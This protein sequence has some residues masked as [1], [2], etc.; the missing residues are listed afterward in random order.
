M[1]LHL[2]ATIPPAADAPPALNK[3]L[4]G[5]LSEF[6]RRT[7]VRLPAFVEH[8]RGQSADDYRP[9]K[10]MVPPVIQ[11]VCTGYQHIDALVDI[12]ASGA[13]VPLLRPVPRQ[14]TYP[15][16]HKSAVEWYPV[17]VKNIRKKQDLWRC[18]VVD[19]DILEIWPEVHI[20][21]FGVVD[22]GDVGP[23]TTGRT[24][25]DLSFPAG[26]S[27]NDCTDTSRICTPTS[28]RCY[29]IAAEVLRQ[30][31]CLSRCRS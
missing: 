28:E 22:K 8:L 23:A 2:P 11:C 12:A 13:R 30:A 7:R 29:A 3:P 17:L 16:N 14:R 6:V 15:A 9:N 25:H 19:L 21:F 18:I 24:I 27:L 10:N 26:H 1:G 20:S 4:Q 5:V 31:R